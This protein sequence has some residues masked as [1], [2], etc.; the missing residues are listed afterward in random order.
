MAYLRALRTFYSWAEDR[1]LI[2]KSPCHRLSVKVPKPLRY[3]VRAQDISTL[4]E[5]CLCIRDRLIVSMLADTGLRLGELVSI[6]LADID[7]QECVIKLWGK[8]ARQR[9]V[10]YGPRTAEYLTAHSP[11]PDQEQLFDLTRSGMAWMLYQLGQRT[12]IKC[13]AHSFRRTFACESVRNG[14]NLFHVQSLLGHA[15]LTMTQVY[16]EMV[17]SEDAIKHY[18]PVVM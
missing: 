9:V 17:N 15:D 4:L 5:A 2:F 7:P 3:A 10:R 1:G 14:M 13:N 8:G 18:R 12:G 11:Q 6:K 16:A